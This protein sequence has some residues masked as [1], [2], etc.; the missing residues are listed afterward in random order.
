VL[1]AAGRVQAVTL[2]PF[3]SFLF[4]HAE[5]GP[6]ARMVSSDGNAGLAAA[7]RSAV[8]SAI[9]SSLSLFSPLLPPPPH[10]VRRDS[11]KVARKR[12][13]AFLLKW[14]EA[15]SGVAA[16]SLPLFPLSFLFF[17]FLLEEV[18]NRAQKPSCKRRGGAA[19]CF[20]SGSAGTR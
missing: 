3:F 12:R 2:Y 8:A 15:V 5:H 19:W 9:P 20:L 16:S 1:V 13:E 17:L 6:S 18:K 14:Q 4:F 11:W 10:G 7:P